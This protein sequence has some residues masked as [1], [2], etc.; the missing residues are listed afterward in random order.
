[1]GECEEQRKG[2]R[3]FRDRSV[4]RHCDIRQQ[5]GLRVSLSFSNATVSSSCNSV[6]HRGVHSGFVHV[7]DIFRTAVAC[8]FDLRVDRPLA[9]LSQ[10]HS[11]YSALLDTFITT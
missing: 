4:L 9:Q 11:Q 7:S 2:R 5:S 3:L 6:P 1:M 8:V 10:T